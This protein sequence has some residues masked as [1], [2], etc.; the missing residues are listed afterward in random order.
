LETVKVKVAVVELYRV[1][2]V[3]VKLAVIVVVPTAFSVAVGV[4]SIAKLA[5]DS[6]LEVYVIEPAMLPETLGAVNAFVDSEKRAE[7][8]E[9]PVRVG[10]VLETASY[11]PVPPVEVPLD[12]V[13]TTSLTPAVKEFAV[14]VPVILV[15]ETTETLVNETPPIVTVDPAIKFVPVIVTETSPAIAPNVGE[16]AETVEALA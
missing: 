14:I 11:K 5:T 4:E 8:F 2:F 13:T 10:V 15:P 1:V 12:V 3:G 6:S 16:I 9:K 7:V